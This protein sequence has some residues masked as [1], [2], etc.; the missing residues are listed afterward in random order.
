MKTD[1]QKIKVYI[2]QAVAF[3]HAK[4][5]EDKQVLV[6]CMSGITR[7]ATVVV[8]YLM[9]HK[10]MSLDDAVNLVRS[11]RPKALTTV[12]YEQALMEL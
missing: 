4:L 10:Q 9:L 8:A 12:R 7:S 1:K 3:I 5:S 11:K 2:N 6:H